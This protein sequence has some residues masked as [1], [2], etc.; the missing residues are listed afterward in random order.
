MPRNGIIEAPI[1]KPQI[2]INTTTRLKLYNLVKEESQVIVHCTYIGRSRIR[3]WK[4]TFLYA[5]GS[6]HRSKMILHENITLYPAWTTYKGKSKLFT[7]IFTSLP[8]SCKEFDLIE[9]IPEPGGWQIKN[10]QRNNIDVYLINI[11]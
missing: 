2:K 11:K 7:L 6:S 10:I 8:K 3:I 9:K 4:S 1:I 5:K